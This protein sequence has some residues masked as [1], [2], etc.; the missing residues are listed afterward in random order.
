MKLIAVTRPSERSEETLKLIEARGFKGLI[1]PSIEI[2]PRKLKKSGLE[3]KGFDWLV[4]TSASGVEIIHKL[5]KDELKNIKIA[6][7]GPKTKEALEK[8]GISPAL[9]AKE[10]KAESLAEELKKEARN[11]KILVARASVG[12]EVLIEELKKVAEVR[13]IELYDTTLPKDKSKM[14]GFKEK[15]EKGEVSAV[16]FTS[17]QAAKNL[18]DFLGKEA[19]KKINKTA[20]CAIGPITAKT[21]EEYGVKISAIPKEYT[22]EAA[23]DEIEKIIT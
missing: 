12:R 5:L 13:E 22:V 2:V 15:L 1:V 7:I 11:K 18:L 6:V 8:K 9:I 19:I 10:Y 16:I 4:L 23:L 3:I 21:L 17:S 20:V 14:L